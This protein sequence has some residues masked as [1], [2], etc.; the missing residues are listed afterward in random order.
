MKHETLP[1]SAL[2]VLGVIIDAAQ[3]GRTLTWRD[4]CATLGHTSPNALTNPMKRLRAAGLVS[5]DPH[6]ARTIRPTCR[7]FAFAES[8]EVA[9][10]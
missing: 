8:M 3:D 1:P 5:F 6:H 2:R 10:T 4:L 7:V 9:K